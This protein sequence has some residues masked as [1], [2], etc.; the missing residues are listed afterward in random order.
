MSIPDFLPFYQPTDLLHKQFGGGCLGNFYPSTIKLKLYG[1]SLVFPTGENAFQSQKTEDIEI[2][3]KFASDKMTPLG[4]FRMGRQV[5]MRKDWDD[6]KLK[7]MED[8]VFAKFDQNAELKEY[9]LSTDDRYLVEH[10]PFK[11]RDA[12]WAD[13]S[14]GTG[15]NHLGIILMKVREK[16]GG[17]GVIAPTKTYKIW[18]VS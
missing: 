14:N 8:L 6:I 3:S 12:Y 4:A 13:D 2:L 16:L 17:K 7:V 15:K 10:T 1:K 18:L 5:K 9:L 11:G